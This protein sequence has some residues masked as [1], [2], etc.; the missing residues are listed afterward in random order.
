M[1]LRRARQ[2]DHPPITEIRMSV[3]EKVLKIG[4]A[5]V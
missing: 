3:K 5:H 4:R 1:T 2:G